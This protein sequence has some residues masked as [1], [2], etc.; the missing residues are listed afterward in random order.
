MALSDPINVRVGVLRRRE[1]LR[2]LA[3]QMAAR[4]G[5]RVQGSGPSFRYGGRGSAMPTMRLP[6]ALPD[7][8]TRPLGFDPEQAAFSPMPQEVMPV[9]PSGASSMGGGQAAT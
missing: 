2:K 4:A 8:R 1:Q 5:G 9:L 6:F 3:A 7:G